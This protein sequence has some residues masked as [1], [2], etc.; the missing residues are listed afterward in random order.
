MLQKLAKNLKVVCPPLKPRFPYGNCLYVDGEEPLVIDAGAGKLAFSEIIPEQVSRVLLSHCHFDHIHSTS[1]FTRA[2]IMA[3][4]QEENCYRQESNWVEY[5]GYRDWDEIM[6]VARFAIGHIDKFPYGDIPLSP[7]FQPIPLA[8]GF[9]DLQ[10]FDSGALKVT[11]LH[12]PGHTLGHYGFYIESEGVLFSGDIDLVKSGPWM[13]ATTSDIDQ[14][15][16]SVQRLKEIRPRVIVPSHRRVQTHD[17]VQQLDAF[18]EV[19]LKRQERFLELLKIPHTVEQLADYHMFYDDFKTRK[20]VYW[21]CMIMNT[22]IAYS[23]RHNLIK[24]ISPGLYQRI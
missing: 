20:Q 22:H 24:E 16:H 10:T 6:F 2:D 23:L 18:M 12:L 14:L 9:T 15:A 17:L 3:G 11:A 7:N 21:E 19:V 13:G 1:L 4:K 5:N 8:G